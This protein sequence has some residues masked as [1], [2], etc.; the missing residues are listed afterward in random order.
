MARPRPKSLQLGSSFALAPRRPAL[1]Q[2]PFSAIPVSG[3]KALADAI[4]YVAQNA[5][6]QELRAALLAL[7]DCNQS[8]SGRITSAVHIIV[9]HL[10]SLPE[11]LL[12]PELLQAVLPIIDGDNESGDPLER[13]LVLHLAAHQYLCAEKERLLYAIINMLGACC[14]RNLRIV[15]SCP[16]I[17]RDFAPLLCGVSLSSS[18]PPGASR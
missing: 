9:T 7:N 8:Q 3:E 17:A 12:S 2:Q 18:P 4:L 16:W 6:E 10:R 5:T 1:H 14:T 13:A 15:H 11:P